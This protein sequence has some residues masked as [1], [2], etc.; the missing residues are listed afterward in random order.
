MAELQM[1]T[2][3]RFGVLKQSAFNTIQST[4]S[5]FHYYAF[6][7]CNYGP[8]EEVAA[9]PLEAGTPRPLP[10]GV[11]KTGLTFAG[12]VRLIPR[13]E[14]RIAYL[15]EATVGDISTYSNQT[16]D[17]QVALK[18]ASTPVS[19]T[20]TG[21]YVHQFVMQYDMLGTGSN[22]TLPYMTTHR[23]LPNKTTASEVG[24]ISQ[25]ACVTSLELSSQAPGV[26][27]ANLGL[28]G[29]GAAISLWD[30]NPGWT[31]PTLDADDT[32]AATACTGFAK[33]SV[34]GGT[35]STLT[36]QNITGVTLTFTNTLLP[37]DQARIVGSPYHVDH[38]CLARAVTLDIPMLV[39]DY[40]LYMQ[41]LGGAADPIADTGWSCSPLE[42]NIDIQWQSAEPI[43]GAG[44]TAYHQMR[45][46]TTQ[47]N[48]KFSIRPIALVPGRPVVFALR[49]QLTRPS[50][51]P[52]FELYIQNATVSYS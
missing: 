51:A 43:A 11:Y 50:S 19:G 18:D 21:V 17:E 34:N 29:R 27:M 28:I 9:L 13:L 23:L 30:K 47:N 15:L 10:G 3:G 44:A 16:I 12:N 45:F 40:D 6:T 32:F 41:C 14:N 33:I 38:P 5:S 22:W 49:A 52:P 42:G 35:P 25:D 8:V 24:E 20:Y 1:G 2:A 46:R 7:E 4:D 48:A 31:A 37:P 26:L 36:T 39:Q